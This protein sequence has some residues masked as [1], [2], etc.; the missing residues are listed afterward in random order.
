MAA[1]L[2]VMVAV[3]P[4]SLNSATATS[5]LDSGLASTSRPPEDDDLSALFP[6]ESWSTAMTALFVRIESVCE[7]ALRM[8]LPSI[9]GEAISAQRLNWH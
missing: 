8:S 1:A 9:N 3:V 4:V 7:V 6:R 2:V 5:P